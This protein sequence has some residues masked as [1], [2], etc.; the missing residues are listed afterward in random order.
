MTTLA[1]TSRPE[2]GAGHQGSASAILLHAS[3]RQGWALQQLVDVI[4]AQGSLCD[5]SPHRILASDEH[6]AQVV[7]LTFRSPHG[8]CVCPPL[9]FT[10][11]RKR[12]SLKKI[13]SQ[14]FPFPSH[15]SV[16]F[17]SVPKTSQNNKFPKS[18]EKRNHNIVN[19]VLSTRYADVWN[20]KPVTAALDLAFAEPY[21]RKHSPQ[22]RRT[23]A[24]A[25]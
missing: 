4:R 7:P 5:C 15:M 13:T 25:G 10:K 19:M 14:M 21:G 24:G 20:L 17:W 1:W 12:G 8:G 22:H 23:Q 6:R 16:G 3:P 2:G 11:K 9:P 18:H